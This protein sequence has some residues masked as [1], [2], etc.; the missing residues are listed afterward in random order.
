MA[1]PTLYAFAA[2][3]EVYPCQNPKNTALC[4][5]LLVKSETY[6]LTGK[7]AVTTNYYKY[8]N[9]REAAETV[10][11]LLPALHEV[12]LTDRA[13]VAEKIG[14][15]FGPRTTEFILEFIRTHP[16]PPSGRPAPIQQ[17]RGAD[18]K[19]VCAA[20]QPVYDLVMAR[21]ASYP[22]E[23][24][25][26]RTAYLN[27]AAALAAFPKSVLEQPMRAFDLEGVGYKTQDFIYE[28]ADRL[29]K[30]RAC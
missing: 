28:T 18:V 19:C 3:G 15:Y 27:A 10:T 20:N 16:L 4:Q 14:R 12:N 8:K 30:G 7:H 1:S 17:L 11:V 2:D 13:E 24:K 9:Y 25:Y 26:N 22:S 5:A 29:R 6:P 21:A 23:K